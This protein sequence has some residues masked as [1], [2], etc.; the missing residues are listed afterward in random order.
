MNIALKHNLWSGDETI[1]LS[2]PDRRNVNVLNMAGDDRRV[3]A[4]DD[5][6]KALAPL[7]AKL[8]GKKEIC[9]VFDDLSRPTRT[10]QILPY[11][12]EVFEKAG[13]RD[14]QVRFLC[15]LC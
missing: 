5:Y 2:L 3:L 7:V 10:Y 15:A 13:V 4:A 12:A 6:R 9:I 14:E 8:K 1:A 11:L